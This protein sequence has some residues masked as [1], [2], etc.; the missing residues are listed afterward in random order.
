MS[1]NAKPLI[2]TLIFHCTIFI[3]TFATIDQNIDKLI[4]SI[5][6]TFS[7]LMGVPTLEKLYH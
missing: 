7:L 6:Q 5:Q 3:I 2:G 4:C 1:F